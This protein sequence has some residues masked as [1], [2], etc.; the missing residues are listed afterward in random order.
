F[1]DPSAW[2]LLEKFG[3]GGDVK[4]SDLRKCSLYVKFDPL[5][6]PSLPRTPDKMPAPTHTVPRRAQNRPHE[7][8]NTS[9]M[10]ASGVEESI[11]LMGT[12]PRVSRRRSI[13]TQRRMNTSVAQTITEEDSVKPVDLLFSIDGEADTDKF[14]GDSA[15]QGDGPAATLVQVEEDVKYTE[16]EWRK[17]QQILAMQYEGQLLARERE[18]ATQLDQK[19]AKIK[20]LQEHVDKVKGEKKSLS[21]SVVSMKSVVAEYEKTLNVLIAAKEKATEDAKKEVDA[22]KKE[23]DQAIEDAQALESSFS[24]FHRRYEKLKATLEGFKKNEEVLKNTV[25]S[26]QEKVKAAD[27]NLIKVKA[28]AEE[29]IKEVVDVLEKT[30]ADKLRLEA[31]LKR[32]QVQLHSLENTVEQKNKEVK[33]L[34]EIC[35]SLISQVGGSK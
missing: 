19:E 4:E 7:P 22:M 11:C 18:F 26:W 15:H 17:L 21:D 28:K 10:N 35:E 14:A 30:K 2:E 31:E 13:L 24:E 33:E 25:K 16:S 6:K 27:E 34:T 9:L 29:K 8:V 3:G 12:P 1:D 20:Q 32:N 23:R 5:V